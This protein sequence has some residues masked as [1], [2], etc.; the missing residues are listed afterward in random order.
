MKNSINIKHP[1]HWVVGKINYYTYIKTGGT[2]SRDN[3]TYWENG[4]IN[5]LSSG[6]VNKKVIFE[7]DNKIT[8]DGLNNS[9]AT[10]LPANSILMALNGQGKT[11]GMVAVLKV[12]ST[13][14]QSLA[15]FIC[16]EDKLHPTYLY[17]QLDSRYKE[18]RGL[19]G[20]GHREGLS[21]SLL[22]TLDIYIPPKNE[23]IAIVN[24]LDKQ[25]KKIDNLVNKQQKLVELLQ[26]KRQSLIEEAVTKGLNRE[27]PMK[28]SGIEWL[29][30]IPSNWKT[31][32][33]GIA[34]EKMTNGYV[35]PTRDILVEDGVRYLQSMHIKNGKILFDRKHYFVD[36]EW[37]KKQSKSILRKGDVL[38]VQTGAEIGQCSV[39]TTEYEGCNC[40][41][42]IIVRLRQ[43]IGL[44]EY[45]TW[46]FQS[47][48]GKNTL[49]S[50][51]TGAL[52]PHLDTGRICNIKIAFPTIE[53]QQQI[54]NFLEKEAKK[55]DQ[56]ISKIEQ[57]I[58]KL[59]EYRQALI[60]E[61]VTGKIDVREYVKGVTM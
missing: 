31:M 42:L 39:V 3:L 5:W 61:A 50:Y 11:K 58:E 13:C 22:K 38:F 54:V 33:L 9:N 16:K 43:H 59:Q 1:N 12:Q 36:K 48:H 35:G 56:L 26:E 4:T 41:A 45:L 17:Y 46:Y 53:E 18:I 57:Q 55:Y 10:M 15:A 60:S 24:F 51:R 40:H 21:I 44:G 29:G 2:P 32:L 34:A 6:E 20:D 27:A 47:N 52:H 30:E 37:S 14:N 19:V 28:D 23:Q 49:L 25:T 7:V 8:V